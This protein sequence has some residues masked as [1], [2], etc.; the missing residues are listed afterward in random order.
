MLSPEQIQA[1]DNAEAQATFD[2]ICAEFY[3]TD[4]W[5]T[6]FAKDA[7]IEYRT[8]IKWMETGSRPQTWS[9]LL[10]ESR[11]EARKI[12]AAL[13][14]ITQGLKLASDLGESV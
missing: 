13:Q 10:M 1:L 11:N 2:T 12:S 14:M 6:L 3:G 7:D 8:V 5:K 9:I 4:R